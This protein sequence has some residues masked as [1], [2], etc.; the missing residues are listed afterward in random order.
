[1]IAVEHL[2]LIRT[3]ERLLHPTS[4]YAVAEVKRKNFQKKENFEGAIVTSLR[5]KYSLRQMKIV[6]RNLMG[7]Q[8]CGQYLHLSCNCNLISMRNYIKGNKKWLDKLIS[9]QQFQL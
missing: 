5:G 1:M 6:F 8:Y 9:K 2:C 4:G 7:N 3:S